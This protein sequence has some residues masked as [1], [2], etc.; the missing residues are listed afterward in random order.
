MFQK[1]GLALVVGPV[2]QIFTGPVQQIFPNDFEGGWGVTWEILSIFCWTGDTKP[3]TFN[4]NNTP[5]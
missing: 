4:T 2:L 5:K 3:P 1:C